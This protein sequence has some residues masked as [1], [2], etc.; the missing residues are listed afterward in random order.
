MEQFTVPARKGLAPAQTREHSST[1]W[2]NHR[3]RITQLYSVQNKSL[4]EVMNVMEIKYGFIATYACELS[5]NP[6]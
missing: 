1:V 3:D 5:W 6:G 4:E 2:E